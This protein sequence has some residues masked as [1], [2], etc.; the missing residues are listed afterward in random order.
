MAADH[1]EVLG[2]PRDAAP[3]DIKKAYRRLAREL[4]PDVNPSPDAAERFK[5]VTHAYDVLSDPEQR[6]AYDSGGGTQ[7]PA[8]FGGF[9]DI[10]DTFFGQGSGFGGGGQQAGPRPRAERGQDALIRVEI[11]LADVIFGTQRELQV[12]TA[13]RCEECDGSG[14]APGTHP[15]TCDVCRG[16]GTIQRQARSL[17]GTVVTSHPCGSCQGYGTIIPNPCP[18]CQG[19]GRVR[20]RTTVTTD[21]PAGID[22]GTR[23]QLRGQGQAGPWGGPNGD[24]FVEFRI[25]HHDIFSRDGDDLLATLEVAMADA[26]LG[27]TARIEGLDGDVE[28]DIKGGT[29]SGDVVT[30]RGRGVTHLRS[31]ARGDLRIGVQVLIPTRLS[32]KE[33]ELMTQFAES[34]KAP[35]PAL[36]E[37]HR[38]LFSRLRDRFFGN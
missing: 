23:L 27:T 35:A 26:V 30:V 28:V 36:S 34:H 6:R 32:A 10:F 15:I 7:G 22:A 29:Q 38:G 2:V 11:E 25:A 19:Q 5:L 4:H 20:A 33:R 9:Q 24:L 8:G 18:T 3:E 13:V 16:S 17:F 14:C 31:S 37:F 21:I 12:D 1:Y